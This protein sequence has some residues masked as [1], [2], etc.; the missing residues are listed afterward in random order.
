MLFNSYIFVFIFLPLV[1]LGWYSLNKLKKY[2]L[3]KVYLAGM[4]LWFYGYFNTYYLLVIII[5]ILINYALSY[6]MTFS[7]TK[8]T[9]KI[10][11]IAGVSI[12]LTILFY[13]K[14][15]DFFIDN[16]NHIFQA[17][18]NLKHILLPLGISFFT[19]QQI[20]F[21]V[22]RCTGKAG[23]YSFINYTTFVTFFP[24]LVAGPIVLYHEMIPQFEDLSKRSF[25]VSN[26]AKGISLFV[27]GLGKKVLLADVLA[28]VTNFGF[29]QTYFLDTPSTVLVILAYTFQIYFDFSG[30]SDMALGLGYMFNIALPVNF[31]SPYK[32]CS[33]KELW[34]R[35]HMTLSRFF[36][37]YVYIPL[38][39]SKK[40][41]LRTIINTMVIFSLSGL[42]HGA[43]WT[44][45]A[46]GTMQGLLVVWDN[47]GIIGIKGN[48]EKVPAKVHIPRWL[49]W[50]FTFSFF[51]LSLFFFRSASMTHALQMFKNLFAFKHTGYIYKLA[52]K[53]DIPEFY[54]VKQAVN[55]LNPNMLPI[56]YVIFFFIVLVISAF[57]ITRKNSFQI[58]EATSYSS[59]F[60]WYIVIVFVWSLISFSQV[61]TFIYFN[62]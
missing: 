44:Y 23:H 20:S 5:S 12:N 14:Y 30:Y 50:F 59:R 17:D 43:N 41:R 49:G 2:E 53:M 1:L 19:F 24:Q 6:L 13:F 51:N 33:V 21:I 46:W 29:E 27:L 35:W 55:L 34:Q 4:S 31:N 37:S 61:S 26:F 58:M 3:A 15:Y 7:R 16:I 39:G 56:T 60:C 8:F 57:V 47:L 28:L 48:Q 42:W 9:N 11:L 38:G 54:I 40:G 32:A 18:F 62:F 25:H 36:V 10:G 52:A 22:D 45:V